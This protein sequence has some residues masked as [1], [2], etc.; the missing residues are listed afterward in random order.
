MLRIKTI[1][2][3]GIVIMAVNRCQN[4]KIGTSF[5][6]YTKTAEVKTENGYTY[7]DVPA[8]NCNIGNE[9]EYALYPDTV[10]ADHVIGDIPLLELRIC[11]EDAGLMDPF[12]SNKY[13][14][15]SLTTNVTTG[16]TFDIPGRRF[17]HDHPLYHIIDYNVPINKSGII[18]HDENCFIMG[19][20]TNLSLLS[21]N[22]ETDDF[23]EA[24]KAIG[25]PKIRR[26]VGLYGTMDNNTGIIMH[27][28]MKDWI[29]YIPTFKN[30]TKVKV[31]KYKSARF[32]IFTDK[33]TIVDQ[34]VSSIIKNDTIKMRLYE[35]YALI[36]QNK[37]INIYGLLQNN[38]VKKE[39]IMLITNTISTKNPRL[40]YRN[41]EGYR[42]NISKIKSL[43][44]NII[45]DKLQINYNKK[46]ILANIVNYVLN[47]KE[48]LNHRIKNTNH[49]KYSEWYDLIKDDL[50]P[51]FAD[52]IRPERM[53][54]KTY[55]SDDKISDV[56]D[57][58]T[59]AIY[60]Q[61]ILDVKVLP[62]EF[63]DLYK[64]Y[65]E[66]LNNFKDEPDV[67]DISAPIISFDK[68]LNKYISEEGYNIFC[69][70]IK[71]VEYITPDLLKEMWEVF[72]DA[73]F[74]N[75]A[76]IFWD[77]INEL[78]DNYDNAAMIIK[79]LIDDETSF[80]II[81][82]SHEHPNYI[83]VKNKKYYDIS[84]QLQY[85]TDDTIDAFEEYDFDE[86]DDVSNLEEMWS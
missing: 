76:E 25:I 42:Y 38:G 45:E 58:I 62:Q 54:L 32:N 51:E 37:Y 8:M 18:R 41:R 50:D 77:F 71:H 80:D 60:N 23:G 4:C 78:A 19:Q 47:D 79:E 53:N 9:D 6:V 61:N 63:K 21:K 20:G 36:K 39:D 52:E 59:D 75:D 86:N 85:I 27:K 40:I 68:L 29:R 33:N 31:V 84:K 3:K 2:V 81:N 7:K 17:D 28:S 34:F 83:K 16:D 74:I 65:K 48:L 14:W 82:I 72:Q 46:E 49:T 26:C 69:N 66:Y 15:E 55:S 56:I 1:L 12:N 10:E 5:C 13:L 57:I 64:Y 35:A 22:W 70:I 73:Y 30:Y 43:Y 11:E 44:F 67:Q 24:K